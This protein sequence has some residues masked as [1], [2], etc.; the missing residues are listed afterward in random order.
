MALA[1]D[2]RTLSVQLPFAIYLEPSYSA[3]AAA[4]APAVP[5][6]REALAA[7]HTSLSYAA[8]MRPAGWLFTSRRCGHGH[9]GSAGPSALTGR[10]STSGFHT[11]LH[12]ECWVA[13]H[14]P[15]LRSR[16]CRFCRS[17]M[18]S[19]YGCHSPMCASSSAI[20]TSDDAVSTS[21]V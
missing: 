13:A 18:K 11:P 21:Q 1:V 9:A 19:W 16:P 2:A 3:A 6:R 17:F 10:T 4:I 12:A 20:C 15:P 7:S 5:V 8:S 14:I